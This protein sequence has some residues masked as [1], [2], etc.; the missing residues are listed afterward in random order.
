MLIKKIK[1]Y[2]ITSANEKITNANNANEKITNANNVNE[3][4]TNANNANEKITDG[5]SA[6]DNSTCIIK[7]KSSITIKLKR[8][9]VIY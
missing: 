3:K 4:I 1:K 7:K 2:L 8:S 5:N 6:N 9:Q